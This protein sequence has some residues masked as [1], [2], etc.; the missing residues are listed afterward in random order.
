MD[1]F[2]AC[3]TDPDEFK[4]LVKEGANVNI[5]NNDGNTPLHY[6]LWYQ[7]SIVEF[8]VQHGANVNIQNKYGNIPLHLACY[9]QPSF[10]K[11]LVQHGANANLQNKYGNTPLEYACRWSGVSEKSIRVLYDK[12]IEYPR[13]KTWTL[14]KIVALY[15]A[16]CWKRSKV[17]GLSSRIITEYMF[18]Q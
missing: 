15:S 10:I 3:H 17:G 1:L 4:R 18:K 8:L 16:M 5:Q 9:S 7:P 6:A 11:F 13:S 14:S 12:S 2:K